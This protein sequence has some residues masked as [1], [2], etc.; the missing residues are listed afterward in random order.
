TGGNLI[1]TSPKTTES[2]LCTESAFGQATSLEPSSTIKSSQSFCTSLSPKPIKERPPMGAKQAYIKSSE[3]HIVQLVS[4][5]K[6]CEERMRRRSEDSDKRGK[7][8][9][10][11]PEAPQKETSSL[12]HVRLGSSHSGHTHH[13][14]SALPDKTL[15][16]GNGVVERNK[17]A[18]PRRSVVIPDNADE[19]FTP[20]PVTYVVSPPHKTTKSKIDRATIKL[21]TSEK[22]C[23]SSTANS[24][25][26]P[27]TG[28]LC[29][30]TQNSTDSGSAHAGD[31]KVSFSAHNPQILMPTVCLQ[32]VKPENIKHLCSKDGE[33]KNS[34]FTSSGRHVTEESD[35]SSEKQTSFI[36]GEESLCP[37]DTNTTASKQT[38]P[39]SFSKS[40]PLERLPSEGSRKHVNEE[41]STDV[42]LGLNFELD[43]DLSQ[44]SHSSED[45]QLLSFQ[46]MM[47][48]VT[49]PPGTPEKGAFSEPST[50]GHHSCQLKTVSS[51][52]FVFIRT[53]RRASPQNNSKTCRS[54][55]FHC[56]CDWDTVHAQLLN[57]ICIFFFFFFYP[58]EFLQ[59]YTLMS[60]A[61]RE[62]AP[63]E[64]V[65][66]LGKFGQIFNKDTLQLRNSKKGSQKFKVWV[67]SLADVTLVLMN[68]G[69]PFVA[70][71]PLENLQPSFTEGDFM[72]LCPWAYSDD[73]LLLL[74]TMV[75]RISLD[76]HLI[77]QS[78]EDLHPV[79]HKVI[80]SIRDWD[81]MVSLPRICLA[82]TDLTDD[83][84]NMCLLVQRLPDNKRGKQLRRHLSLSMISKL[85]DGNCTYRPIEKE[86][87][88]MCFSVTY[89]WII[90]FRCQHFKL[91][92]WCCF[93][94][95]RF[96]GSQG[97]LLLLC[98][99][100]ETHV[101]CDIRE[102]EK[103]LYR[104]KV[105]DLVARISTKWQMLL[106]RTR[107]LHVQ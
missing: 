55:L 57:V 86:F 95:F 62:V 65:F 107:P 30:K 38:S 103:C 64:V 28:S 89:T 53:K 106:Q 85:L 2:H 104:S 49:K 20:D 11:S 105:K 15:S 101:K 36:V 31:T 69:V 13:S 19:L 71:F 48:R 87:Q 8:N 88:V 41:D 9:P 68:M 91:V 33:L 90:F 1:S 27:V 22:S 14:T 100:L 47:A 98:S 17:T 54:T 42:E 59:R 102:S 25:S 51:S 50:P 66:N 99:E 96:S 26:N 39:S 72:N 29:H 32:R 4:S 18:R 5:S 84:H 37:L 10:L 70:L 46:E 45:E 7:S 6:P 35:K 61:I 93:F 79:Q 16:R 44:S 94:T 56:T 92:Q 23:S 21:P 73:E 67:P 58:R 12:P 52:L 60:N 24:S 63:G 77:L 82:L 3:T 43:L 76:T 81:T 83:H 74:L 78:G 97:Q 80:D 75:G 40:S 34:R